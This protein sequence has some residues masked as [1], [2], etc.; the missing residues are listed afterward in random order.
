MMF[1]PWVAS[2]AAL[3]IVGFGQIA[4]TFVTPPKQEHGRAGKTT[5][6]VFH[7]W[8]ATFRRLSDFL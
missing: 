1:T 6:A 8:A 7:L 5:I 3:S 2:R 4:E